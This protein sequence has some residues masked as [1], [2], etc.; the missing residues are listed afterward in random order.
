FEYCIGGDSDGDGI[1]DNDLLSTTGVG[2]ASGTNFGGGD[3][4]QPGCSP[5][6]GGEDVVY[7][8]TSPGT[9]TYTFSSAGSDYDTVLFILESCVGDELAC[10]DDVDFV[11]ADY[12]SQVDVFVPQ[13]DTITIV[14]DAYEVTESGNYLLDIVPSY[15]PD[16]GDGVDNDGDGDIDCDDS[17][18]AF[19]AAC[20]AATCPNYDLL[21]LDSMVVTGNNTNSTD[22]TQGTC[23]SSGGLDFNFLWTAPDDGCLELD[24]QGSTYDTT[25]YVM[26][27]CNGSVLVCN[28]D[29]F[30]VQS[31]LSLDVVAGEDYTLVV[32]GYSSFSTGDYIMN[33]AFSAG[34]S[35]N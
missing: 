29:S 1:L 11:N 15:E 26:D 14:I 19:D 20:A 16:C 32:D 13:G 8:W 4:F 7:Q 12:T 31:Y 30:G 9:G 18:C 22:Q 21:D 5:G 25:L 6:I 3:D 35:C 28:D 10:N 33:L 34:T 23:G 24:T 17:D 27:Q 2:I